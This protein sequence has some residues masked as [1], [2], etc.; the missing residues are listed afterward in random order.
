[1][2]CELFPR[3]S[4]LPDEKKKD[5]GD[6]PWDF[7]KKKTREMSPGTLPESEVEFTGFREMISLK[8]SPI[9]AT[10]TTYDY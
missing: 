10:R 6:V 7:T 2:G 9:M 4:S 3:V 8:D 1:M 5:K